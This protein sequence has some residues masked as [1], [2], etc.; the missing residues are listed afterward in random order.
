MSAQNIPEHISGNTFNGIPFE[1]GVNGAPLNLAGALI[2]L[3][4]RKSPSHAI[5]LYLSTT[6]SKIEITN[7]ALGQFRIKRQIITAIPAI[8]Q[9]QIIITLANGEVKTYIAGKWEINPS[10]K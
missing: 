4:A 7:G 5:G 3:Y 9:Y 2:E 10:L 6:N 1:V 8:Y